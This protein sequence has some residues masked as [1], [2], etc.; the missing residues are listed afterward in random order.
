[1]PRSAI[2]REVLEAAARLRLAPGSRVLLLA[3]RDSPLADSLAA[4]G[5][6]AHCPD[7]S[8]PLP[9]PESPYAAALLCDTLERIEWDRWIVQQLPPRLA[10][11]APLVL[12][13]RNLASLASLGDAGWLAR[14]ALREAAARAR[15]ALHRPAGTPPF[16][17]RRYTAARLRSLLERAGFAIETLEPRT[18]GLTTPLAA[19]APARARAFARHWLVV[20]RS[21]GAA[22]SPACR[23]HA[24]DF[25]REQAS[26]LAT[27]DAWAA[28]HPQAIAPAA[29]ELDP[30]AFAGATALVFAPHP[31]DE[32]I[33]CGGTL[34]RL[35]AAGAR[36]LCVH[37]TDGSAAHALRE[38]PEERRRT[39]RLEEARAVARAAG[40][41]APVFWGADNRDFC[42]SGELVER[43]ARLLR[44]ER[45]RLVFTSLLTDIHPDHLT[46]NQILAEAIAMTGEALTETQVLGY[47]VW[48]LAPASLACDV[49]NVRAEHEALLWTYATAMKVDDFVTLCERRNHWHACRL[50]GREGYAET[51]HAVAARD[52]PPLVADA[53]RG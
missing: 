49:T 31:D 33:G 21:R 26:F 24:P 17:G 15:R 7:A 28:R 1:M 29:R 18:P 39:V 47:E 52:F 38:A 19:L 40:F 43:A 30:R 4:A 6:V 23:E 36:V 3:R 25:E 14:R 12:A 35:A 8:E 27:R 20:A 45:P 51:F 41:A 5:L 50:L 22:R 46:L 9:R 10:Q 53:L 2:E 37:A 13:A 34:L 44:Q 16:C 32:I 48:A 11:G 42:C